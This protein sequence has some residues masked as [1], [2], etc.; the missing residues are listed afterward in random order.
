GRFYSYAIE[1]WPTAYRIAPGHRLQLRLTSVD[2]PTH[3]PGSISFDRNRP[4]DARI[5]LLSPAINTVRF[6]D[7]Y[8]TLPVG[9]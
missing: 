4:Q 9:P 1:I 5:D 2:V 7:S 8:L 6:D 3:L